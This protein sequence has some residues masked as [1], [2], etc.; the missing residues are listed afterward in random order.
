ME[1][2]S[3]YVNV[4]ERIILKEDIYFRNINSEGTKKPA[5]SDNRSYRFS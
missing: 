2:S 1:G 3:L 4:H 5:M